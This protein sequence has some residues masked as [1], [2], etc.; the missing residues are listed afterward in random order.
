MN[1]HHPPA[2]PGIV[3]PIAF[4]RFDAHYIYGGTAS[5]VAMQ[6][7]L[8]RNQRERLIGAGSLEMATTVLKETFLGPYM[9]GDT[10]VEVALKA[11]LAHVKKE[12][13]R[14][15]PNQHLTNILFL[16]YDFYNLKVILKL[17]K[18]E[19]E[20]PAVV[21]RLSALGLHHPGVL[22]KA[23]TSGNT[24]D[25]HPALAN[26]LSRALKNRENLDND[27]ECFY[28]SAARDEA[29]QSGK[30][31]A[32][33]YVT[34]LTNLF[35]IIAGLRAHA[36]GRTPPHPEHLPFGYKELTDPEALLK[37]LSHIGW[38]KH[39]ADAVTLYR[40]EKDFSVIDKAMDDFL[41]KWIKR[42][43]VQIDSAA[44]F[45]AYWHVM[46]ENVAFVRAVHTAHKVGLPEKTLRNIIRTSYHA[47]VY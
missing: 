9:G 12:L 47:Y 16:R 15:V 45:F 42:Q 17:S 28:L 43:S 5:Y 18:K 39:W 32:V 46:R 23:A 24:A 21:T 33:R 8:D 31:F 36:Q 25:L 20:D 44:P 30:A 6:K 4:A 10:E 1:N 27:M 14:S 26:A 34:I 3:D 13:E 19:L 38:S 35:A 29:E 7:L 37:R 2:L 22:V 41:M 40:E 11:A